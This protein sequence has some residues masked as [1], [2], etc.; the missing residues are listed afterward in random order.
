ME[1]K[2]LLLFTTIAYL[3]SHADICTLSFQPAGEILYYY[4]CSATPKIEVKSPLVFKPDKNDG[5]KFEYIV[6]Y[7]NMEKPPLDTSRLVI[8][9]MDSSGN[10]GFWRLK[11]TDKELLSN[12]R[13]SDE[14]VMFPYFTKRQYETGEEWEV[15]FPF[16][17]AFVVDSLFGKP[18][19][20]HFVKAK[21]RL[22]RVTNILGYECAE[23][24][25][26]FRDTLYMENGKS[27]RC[28]AN[29]TV[30]FAINEGFILS[31]LMEIEYN[32]L[33]SERISTRS[34]AK[35]LRMIRYKQ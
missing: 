14:P 4:D 10:T 12:T 1:I 8:V 2:K 5:K 16:P 32:S 24:T 27:L 22:K 31:D 13:M 34:F 23:I 29:G 30:F 18:V 3:Q 20:G 33:I 21:Q 11:P 25:Y 28:K 6:N 7:I 15:S 35:K 9:N 26:S 17:V 19:P